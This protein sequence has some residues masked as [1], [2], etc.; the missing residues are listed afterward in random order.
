MRRVSASMRISHATL[1]SSL[2]A[3]SGSSGRYSRCVTGSLPG[4]H[5]IP[6][7]A[8]GDRARRVG[9]LEQ[10]RQ[11]HLVGVRKAGFLA[12]DGAHADALFDA[13]R[14]ILDDAVFQRP[15]FLA[16]QLKIQIGV[17]HAAAHD[18]VEHL[19]QAPL[20]ETRRRQDHLL[21]HREGGRDQFGA[22]RVHARAVAA[23]DA[24]ALAALERPSCRL[25]SAGKRR[26]RFRLA[27]KIDVGCDHSG[28]LAPNA[29]T[30][31]PNSRRSANRRRSRGRCYAG[32]SAPA[33]PHSTDFRWPALAATS[34]SARCPVG[35]VNAAGIASHSA[36]RDTSS[37]YSSGKAHV[38]ADREPE[39]PHR[40]IG[41]HHFASR[42]RRGW[43]PD[44]ARCGREW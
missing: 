20:I 22:A 13:V 36:P 27:G 2:M 1:S 24:R 10:G 35:T 19:A 32:R 9:S 44:T 16:R 28:T 41:N 43:I 5:G 18:G 34:P 33:R 23:F 21:G 26:A 7:A 39:P 14:A 25:S 37:R 40:R 29:T 6:A 12:A 17:I 30:P 11:Q 42:K 4:F 8:A 3:S 38:V 15:G 31:G